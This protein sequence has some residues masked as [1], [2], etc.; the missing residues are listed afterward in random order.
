MAG[1]NRPERGRDNASAQLHAVEG[2]AAAARRAGRR[3]EDTGQ[4]ATP[5]GGDDEQPQDDSFQMGPM[6]HG[7]YLWPIFQ[8][9]R[10]NRVIQLPFKVGPAGPRSLEF[11]FLKKRRNPR[12]RQSPVASDQARQSLTASV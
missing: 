10:A 4:S 12:A 5:S 7:S 8:A 1:V 3:A 9:A 6:R 11:F 2:R